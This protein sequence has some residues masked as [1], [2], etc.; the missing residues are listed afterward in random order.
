[1]P[2]GTIGLVAF[3][4]VCVAVVVRVLAVDG[5]EPTS[6]AAWVLVVVFLP[7][8]GVVIYL[9]FGEIWVPR[10]LRRR[11][12]AVG[13]ELRQRKTADTHGVL[14]SVAERFHPVVHTCAH[15]AGGPVTGHNRATLAANANAA[16]DGMVADIDDARSTV[17]IC[18]YIWLD[19]CNG[20]KVVAAVERA[21]KRGVVC[22]VAADG[23]GSRKLIRSRHWQAMQAAGAQMCVSM[24]VP[25]GLAI[26]LGSRMDLRNHR[27]IVVVD[28]R[29]T[30]CGS[31]N[32]ADPEFRVKARFAPWVDIML[33][34]EG[35]VVRQNQA[36]FASG[37]MVETGEDLMPLLEADPPQP[38][39]DNVVAVAFGT[40]PISHPGAMSNVFVGLLSSAEREVVI[41]NPY[42]V[43]DP[44]LMA[45]LT[46]CAR[47]GVDISLILPARNDSWVVAA[48]SK[49]HYAALVKAGVQIFEFCDGLL[50]AKTLVVDGSVALIGSANM[51]R[52]S[53][54]LNLENSILL[55]SREV[56]GE[57]RSR[58]DS[59]LA[60]SRAVSP[61]AVLDRP[62]LR[63]IGDNIATIVGPVM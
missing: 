59:W 11:A 30:W 50:H 22:R 28:N 48:I 6:R 19:D 35:P 26:L 45:A 29:V 37:W 20:R 46:S 39:S 3:T 63:R 12:R 42:F 4:I 32:C 15:L 56:A 57:I 10:R 53:L 13:M 31:Q 40:G 44:P 38:E 5:K 61:Q 51:D 55:A 58:Q 33:R 49:A 24:K 52:R 16:I 8:F 36:L 25:R 2:V 60:K 41:S 17:H 23:I 18:F 54:D 62:L 43:P 27:K 34:F 14:E 7:V 47:R 9:L 21:A 1:M